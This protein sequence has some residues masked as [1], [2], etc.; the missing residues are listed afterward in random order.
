M[1][2]TII[3][4]LGLASAAAAIPSSVTK[5]GLRTTGEVVTGN[6]ATTSVNDADGDGAGADQYILH[7]GD[8][9]F[10]YPDIEQWVNFDD[11]FN[12]NSVAMGESCENN[13]WGAN[14]SADEI[15]DIRAA[16]ESVAAATLVDHRFILAI[17]MQESEG[18]VR[19]PTT[20]G[21]V[22]NP[23]LMQDHDG[24]NSCAGVDPCPA[25]TITGMVSDGTAGTASGDGLANCINEAQSEFGVT[26][27]QAFYY[28][29]RIYNSGSVP[30]PSDLGDAGG[31]TPCYVSDVANRLTGWVFAT[32]TC[33][34]SNAG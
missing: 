28:A 2:S 32:N 26:G 33:N 15:A 17:I 31:A 25:S 20:N 14:D 6:A 22:V 1:K 7:T 30:D 3:A 34:D 8:G 16:I 11:M 12:A 5:L 19:V 9:A 18:C 10:G 21:G 13:G 27:A 24:S 29:A 4:A 23:G